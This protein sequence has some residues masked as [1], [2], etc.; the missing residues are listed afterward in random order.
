MAEFGDVLWR[1]D[2]GHV[3]AAVFGGRADVD[4]LHA[5]GFFGEG[6]PVRGELGVVGEVVVVADVEA[7]GLFRRGDFAWGVD[8][9]AEAGKDCEQCQD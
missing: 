5:V 6:L 7:E 1:G 3:L 8:G 9:L 2:D 4:E